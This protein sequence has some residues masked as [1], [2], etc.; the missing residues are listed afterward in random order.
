MNK[1]LDPLYS[2]VHV[3]YQKEKN[4]WVLQI[5]FAKQRDAGLYECQVD[6]IKGQGIQDSRGAR[7]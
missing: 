4:D 7:Y 5:K 3:K 1:N 6:I 2:R